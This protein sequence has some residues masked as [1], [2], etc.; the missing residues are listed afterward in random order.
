MPLVGNE[1][2]LRRTAFGFA[3]GGGLP[4]PVLEEASPDA[5]RTC[6]WN[7]HWCAFGDGSRLLQARNG[8]ID[9]WQLRFRERFA[10][11]LMPRRRRRFRTN[12]RSAS[13][14]GARGPDVN[15]SADRALDHFFPSNCAKTPARFCTRPCKSA[16]EN[17]VF[18][19]TACATWP[20]VLAQIGAVAKVCQK[21]QTPIFLERNACRKL[22][23]L[24][25]AV[26]KVR[27]GHRPGGCTGE[28]VNG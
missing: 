14:S 12:A 15:V 18:A 25:R 1:S 27:Q 5:E 22:V 26:T 20:G 4:P 8:T 21:S 11:T 2:R 23:E 7:I 19:R 17:T 10:K 16:R 13:A 9:L 6:A 24:P 28:E 3:A